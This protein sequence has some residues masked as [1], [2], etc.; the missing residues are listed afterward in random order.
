LLFT[1]IGVYFLFVDPA[2]AIILFIMSIYHLFGWMKLRGE[3]FSEKA[4][5]ILLVVLVANA[6]FA[7]SMH[8]IVFTLLGLL[9]ILYAV[10]IW[11]SYQ[12]SKIEEGEDDE[13]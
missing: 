7:F 13:E 4:Y 11:L 12:E 10:S 6:L 5:L 8:G 2:I 9:T 3:R 1:L